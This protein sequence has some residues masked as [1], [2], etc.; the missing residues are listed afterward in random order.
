[1]K[2]VPILANSRTSSPEYDF[3][4]DWN[5]AGAVMGNFH[6]GVMYKG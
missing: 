5:G 2:K 4:K 6:S 1:M 3:K